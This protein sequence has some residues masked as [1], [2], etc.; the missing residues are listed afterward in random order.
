MPFESGS[1]SRHRRDPRFAILDAAPFLHLTMTKASR[2]STKHLGLSRM[3]RHIYYTCCTCTRETKKASRGS[4]SLTEACRSFDQ[5]QDSSAL[6][7]RS[8]HSRC[9]TMRCDACYIEIKF[10]PIIWRHRLISCAQAKFRMQ[11]ISITN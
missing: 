8:S 10:S 6:T 5:W 1:R 9:D 7:S 2:S 4:T 11:L 3:D